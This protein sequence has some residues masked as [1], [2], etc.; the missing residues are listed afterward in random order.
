MASRFFSEPFE[1]DLSLGLAALERGMGLPEVF[2][3]D[4]PDDFGNGGLDLAAVDE[5]GHFIQELALFCDVG[6]SEDGVGTR[7]VQNRTLSP[8]ER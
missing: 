5:S 7:A 8:N 2:G 3:V 4:R 6:G 1:N